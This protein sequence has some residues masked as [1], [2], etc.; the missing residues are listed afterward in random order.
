MDDVTSYVKIAAYLGAAFVVGIG[1]IGPS[2]AQGS[3]GSKA[4]E[5][6][7]KYPETN[8]KIRIAMLMSL[9]IIE[10]S[11]VYAL[12]IALLLIFRV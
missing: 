2:L 3:V 8:S 11:C 6:I 5:I 4:C 7:G 12:L 10:A 1:C 9:G